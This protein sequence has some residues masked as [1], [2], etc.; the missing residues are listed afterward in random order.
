MTKFVDRITFEGYNPNWTPSRF[1]MRGYKV[2]MKTVK[3]VKVTNKFG[4]SYEGWIIG[5]DTEREVIYVQDIEGD[6][7]IYEVTVGEWSTH[8]VKVIMEVY[9]VTKHTAG[10]RYE[11]DYVYGWYNGQPLL[12]QDLR[13]KKSLALKLVELGV[14][15]KE[16]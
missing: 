12:G 10:R 5:E 14:L 2:G 15:Y 8:K 16:R 4:V 3:K 7:E 13:T 11:I 6:G 1:E 9:K